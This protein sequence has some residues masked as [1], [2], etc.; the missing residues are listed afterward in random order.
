MISV[1]GHELILFLGIRK[2]FNTCR[3]MTYICFETILF[4]DSTTLWKVWGSCFTYFSYI[5]TWWRL[6][7]DG[8]TKEV[9]GCIICRLQ[10]KLIFDLNKIHVYSI[11]SSM[12]LSLIRFG[13]QWPI[14]IFIPYVSISSWLCPAIDAKNSEGGGASSL[15]F[16]ILCGLLLSFVAGKDFF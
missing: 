13:E 1:A 8:R 11:L 7:G 6:T 3:Y 4:Y 14:Y 15:R 10:C 5:N 16:C 9:T 12:L 2:C